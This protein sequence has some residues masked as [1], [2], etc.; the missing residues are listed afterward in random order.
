MEQSEFEEKVPNCDR[1][2]W[3]KEDFDNDGEGLRI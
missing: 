1:E 3:K 2:K